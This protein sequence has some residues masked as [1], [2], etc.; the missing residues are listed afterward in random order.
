M[1][2]NSS[3]KTSDK[4]NKTAEHARNIW[5]EIMQN[6][7]PD[8]LSDPYL[9]FT[10][11]LFANVWTRPGL[12]R[13]ERR[14][15]SLSAIA[16]RGSAEALPHHIRAALQCGDLTKEELLEWV[17]HLAHYAGWPAGAEAY[18][19]VQ[20][21]APQNNVP[22]NNV[23][24]NNVPQNNAVQDGATQDTTARDDTTQNDTLQADSNS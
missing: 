17:V 20:V 7:P 22:Q 11:N 6:E 13:K 14:L 24:Q 3:S 5:R 19:A 23:P 21:A 15:I 1:T 16:S 2:G 12:S 4:T 9:Q 18:L 10:A 8:D